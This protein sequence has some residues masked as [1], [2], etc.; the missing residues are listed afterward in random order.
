MCQEFMERA[1]RPQ[2][3]INIELLEELSNVHELYEKLKTSVTDPASGVVDP[4]L[5]LTN[6]KFVP[7]LRSSVLDFYKWQQTNVSLPR[8]LT[9]SRSVRLI[10]S[11]DA[12]CVSSGP[13]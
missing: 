13:G 1:S 6:K 4:S 2:E 5:G 9:S 11:C 8:V 7:E 3:L 10:C 12:V